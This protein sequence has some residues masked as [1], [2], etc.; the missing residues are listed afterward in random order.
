MALIFGLEVELAL[1]GILPPGMC[2]WEAVA[3]RL[4]AAVI[5][6]QLHARGA[7]PKHGAFV[8]LANGSAIGL[9]SSLAVPEYCSPEC[10]DPFELAACLRAG[11]RILARAARE[12]SDDLHTR[13]MPI[14]TSLCY[15]REGASLG[16]HENYG[17]MAEADSVA[18]LVEASVLPW[19]V[20]R[21]L[22]TEPG[23]LTGERGSNG[24]ALSPRASL[25]MEVTGTNTTESRAIFTEGRLP[26]ARGSWR[27]LHVISAGATLSPWAVALR[28]G[29]TGLLIEMTLRGWQPRPSLRPRWPLQALRAVSLDPEPSIETEGGKVAPLDLLEQLADEVRRAHA[30]CPLSPWADRVLAEWE[31]ALALLRSRSPDSKLWIEAH[32]RHHIL[33]EYL[34]EAGLGWDEARFWMQFV[35]R[36]QAWSD[37]EAFPAM[38]PRVEPLGGLRRRLSPLVQRGLSALLHQHGFAWDQMPRQRHIIERLQ[39]LDLELSRIEDGIADRQSRMREELGVEVIDGA[40][41]ER[42][43][44]EPPARTRAHRRGVLIRHHAGDPSLRACWDKLIVD[45]RVYLFGSPLVFRLPRR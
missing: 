35:A 38:P 43:E 12:A 17:F 34:R 32:L 29:V 25:M 5:A 14:A 30:A 13:L 23:F 37:L 40:D 41:V 16:T 10:L 33:E 31:R 15:V 2:G 21:Q 27:R 8:F 7:C 18:R 39:M 19:I 26:Y 9:D 28:H 42:L 22:F 11:M 20:T 1:R 6:S 44:R 45:G 3:R 36:M 24:F 4:L